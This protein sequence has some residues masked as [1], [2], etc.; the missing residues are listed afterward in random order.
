M[1]LK[2]KEQTL[3]INQIAKK[4]VISPITAKK[5][6]KKL[7]E[8]GYVFIEEEGKLR[9]YKTKGIKNAKNKQTKKN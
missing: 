9:D 2:Y 7:E 8:E 1:L 6:L 4:I 5:H 3:T